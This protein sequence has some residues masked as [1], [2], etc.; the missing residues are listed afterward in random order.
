MNII[1]NH[2]KNNFFGNT[3]AKKLGLPKIFINNA[4]FSNTVYCSY[5]FYRYLKY[6]IHNINYK[7]D[8]NEPKP[9]KFKPYNFKVSEFSGF[10]YAESVKL[11]IIVPAYNVEKYITQCLDSIV[12]AVVGFDDYEILVVEDCSTD[13]TSALL[14]KIKLN[15][16]NLRLIKN[17]KN[18]GL[19]GARN[20]ALKHS[21]GQYVTFVDSDDMLSYGIIAKVFQKIYNKQDIDIIEFSFKSYFYEQEVSS[22]L[23]CTYSVNENIRIFD[24][25]ND[26]YKFAQGFACGKMYKRNL[27]EFVRFPEGLYWEDAI[28]SNIILRKAKKYA[29]LDSVGYLY[30]INP[31]GISNS[32]EKRNLGYDQFY[33]VQYCLKLAEQENLT[34]DTHFYRRL[35]VEASIYLNSRTSYLPEADLLYMFKQLESIFSQT[36]L[37]NQLAKKQKLMLKAMRENKVAAWRAISF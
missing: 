36:D 23:K 19:S 37:E 20:N 15:Y 5:Q 21:R 35:F 31:V 9:L 3:V 32:V 14:D 10:N 29:Y 28:I 2:Q 34:D 16:K 25:L 27:F 7:K 13:N 6:S 1:Y 30:R 11:S 22:F 26:M 33:I 12:S 4:F 17:E 8:S 18:I 24:D